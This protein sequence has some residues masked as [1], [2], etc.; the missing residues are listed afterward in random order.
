MHSVY[1]LSFVLSTKISFIAIFID[2][3]FYFEKFSKWLPTRNLMRYASKFHMPIML[4][5]HGNTGAQVPSEV[6][7]RHPVVSEC[8]GGVV[9]PQA[10]H[11]SLLAVSGVVQEI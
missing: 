4:F 9:V 3:R 7:H 8:H 1:G 10:V 5:N 6:V 2:F 11:G